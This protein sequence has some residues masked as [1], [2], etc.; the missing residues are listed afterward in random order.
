MRGWG[1]GLLASQVEP[2][3]SGELAGGACATLG[4]SSCPMMAPIVAARAWA[5]LPVQLQSMPGKEQQA[6]K[7]QQATKELRR[8]RDF[9]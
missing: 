6:V 5:L 4:A 7:G 1:A 9:K 8:C 3:V 2:E